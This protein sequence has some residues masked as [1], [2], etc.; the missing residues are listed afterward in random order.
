[1]TWRSSPGTIRAVPLSSANAALGARSGP[2]PSCCFVGSMV[3]LLSSVPERTLRK[4]CE[5]E[6]GRKNEREG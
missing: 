2:V 3:P 1:M 5:G 4:E 6:S